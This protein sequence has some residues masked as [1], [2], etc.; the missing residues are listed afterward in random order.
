KATKDTLCHSYSNASSLSL[1]L[2][3][4]AIGA[5]LKLSKLPTTAVLIYW[6]ASLFALGLDSAEKFE[7]FPSRLDPIFSFSSPS[8]FLGNQTEVYPAGLFSVEMRKSLFACHTRTV[9]LKG[10][11]V[12]LFGSDPGAP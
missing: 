7:H 5:S 12:N 4:I 1:S 6:A 11:Y 8:H 2:S 10:R 9:S 3:K